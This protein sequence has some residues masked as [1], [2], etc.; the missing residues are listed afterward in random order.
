M[1]AIGDLRLSTARVS[2]V[3]FICPI[4]G[5]FYIVGISTPA[6][7]STFDIDCGNIQSQGLDRNRI[8]FNFQMRALSIS[9][10]CLRKND[11]EA[12][13]YYYLGVLEGQSRWINM[14]WN[15][16]YLTSKRNLSYLN[17]E[18]SF[19]HL[20]SCPSRGN[21]SNVLW[22]IQLCRLMGVSFA[23]S[24]YQIIHSFIR[25]RL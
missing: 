9:Y 24:S 6:A 13:F 16:C 25:K 20:W 8:S 11:F 18:A 12:I 10:D 2:G 3:C 22:L 4:G 19:L 1:L 5:V 17:S 14:H 23:C 21:S 7:I 15:Y